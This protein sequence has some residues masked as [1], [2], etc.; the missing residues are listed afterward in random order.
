MQMYSR[1]H[2]ARLYSRE[3]AAGMYPKDHP[4]HGI[5]AY[6][7]LMVRKV[8][9]EKDWWIYIEPR[10]IEETHIEEL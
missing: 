8:Y 3:E 5:S 7:S 9:D 1:L 4:Q 10:V 2:R 6:D